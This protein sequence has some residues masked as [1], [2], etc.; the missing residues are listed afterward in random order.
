ME[1]DVALEKDASHLDEIV[2]TALGT[3]KRKTAI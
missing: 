1:I 2:F 3:E